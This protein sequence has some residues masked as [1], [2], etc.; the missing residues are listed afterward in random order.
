MRDSLSVLSQ[1]LNYKLRLG[2]RA[3]CPRTPNMMLQ[4]KRRGYWN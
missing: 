2:I 3:I 4:K 1:L